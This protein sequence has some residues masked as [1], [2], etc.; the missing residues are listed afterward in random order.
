ME[1]RQWIISAFGGLNL[2]DSPGILLRRSHTPTEAGWMHQGSWGI[3]SPNT[4][5]SDVDP[6]EGIRQRL[7]ST[8][9]DTLAALFAVGETYID[10]WEWRSPATNNRIEIAVT[11]AGVYTNQSGSW[12][13]IVRPYGTGAFT[14]PAAIAKLSFVEIDGHL[15]ILPDVGPILVYRNGASLDDLLY[16]STT[17]TTVNVD[18]NSGQ[19]VLNVAATTHI[20]VYSRVRVNSGGAR[21]ETGYVAAKTGT[22]LTL[23]ANL[24]YTHTAAQADVVILENR[25][26]GAFSGSYSTVNG[27]WRLGSYIGGNLKNRLLLTNGDSN[28]EYLPAGTPYA[29]ATG[30]VM[31]CSGNIIAYRT[32][33]PV[34]SD[35]FSSFAYTFTQAGLVVTSDPTGADFIHLASVRPPINHRAL[36]STQFWLAYLTQEGN[37]HL[38][39]RDRNIDVGR[40]FRSGSSATGALDNLNLSAAQ[41]VAFAYF[42]PAKRQAMFGVPVGAGTTVTELLVL[43]FQLGEPILDEDQIS[44]ERHVRPLWWKIASGQNWFTAMYRRFGATVGATSSGVL[45]QTESGADDLGTHAVNGWWDSPDFDAGLPR[46]AKQWMEQYVDGRQTGDWAVFLSSY[47]DRN[48]ATERADW[49]YSQLSGGTAVYGTGVYGTAVY[50]A[51]K[52]IFG[53]TDVDLYSRSYRFRLYGSGATHKWRLA[54]A[55]TKYMVGAEER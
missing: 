52:T 17:T 33:T 54:N 19:A 27:N 22:T 47:I 4:V 29:R 8:Q 55:V 46:H 34:A 16:N 20:P 35:T 50:G 42:D 51:D 38:V 15:L 2:N 39:N 40:R 25:Y 3:E 18:S 28:M 53:V 14:W 44:Y 37:I 31:P 30:G 36:C 32:L 43:D 11:T 45:Y 12:V 24:T 49:S 41:T 23:Q 26:V 7:G 13:A 48:P 10:G 21:D 6:S 1:I 9:T 5:N